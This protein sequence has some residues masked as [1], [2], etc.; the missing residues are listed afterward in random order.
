MSARAERPDAAADAPEADDAERLAG[1]PRAE[2][3]LPAPRAEGAVF[4]GD[5]PDGGDDEADRVLDRGLART[6]GLAERP[7]EAILHAARRARARA[8]VV[9]TRGAGAFRP[10]HYSLSHTFMKVLLS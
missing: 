9:G 2:A 6:A 10:L 1:K 8:I 5:G 3:R 4:L 7:V